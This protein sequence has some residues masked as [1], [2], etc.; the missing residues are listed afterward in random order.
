MKFYLMSQSIFF[1]YNTSSKFVIDQIL[2]DD[3]EVTKTMQLLTEIK[4]Y[5]ELFKLKIYTFIYVYYQ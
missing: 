4:R 1:L 2:F 5:P 3:S